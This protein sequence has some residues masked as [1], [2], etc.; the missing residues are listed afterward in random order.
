ME[1]KVIKI[2]G[3]R[4]Y[5]FTDRGGNERLETWI[6]VLNRVNRE[7]GVD[8]KV[9]YLLVGLLLDEWQD[10]EDWTTDTNIILGEMKANLEDMDKFPE[11]LAETASNI[12]KSLKNIEKRLKKLENAKK[13][14][15]KAKSK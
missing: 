7:S 2:I 9:C 12:E 14:T 15:Q 4:R 5:K 11:S 1:K 6:D 3:T 13:P 10:V 8:I